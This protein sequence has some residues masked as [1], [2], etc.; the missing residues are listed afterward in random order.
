MSGYTPYPAIKNDSRLPHEVAKIERAIAKTALGSDML[1]LS[2]HVDSLS[3][4]LDQKK[5]AG[6]IVV[7]LEQDP[8]SVPLATFT[9]QQPIVL[10][11]GNEVTGI[12]PEVLNRADVV[13]EIPM[14]GE[15]ESL[16][17]AV[18]AGIALFSLTK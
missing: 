11:V 5:R 17:V 13:A 18:A 12:E 1:V 9:A 8:R 14:L 10:I 7:A 2:T 3:K 15:K 4:Y 6:F 16:N